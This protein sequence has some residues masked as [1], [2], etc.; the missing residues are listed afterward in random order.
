MI[1][2]SNL[3][4][5]TVFSTS[6]LGLPKMNAS[7][8]QAR[9]DA[10]IAA[11]IPADISI[12]NDILNRLHELFPQNDTSL[13]GRFNT[14]DS[15]FD[16][17]EAWFTDQMYLSPRRF[18]FEHVANLQPLF[19]YLFDEFFPG[20]DPNLG[21]FHGSELSLIFGGAPAS[22]SSIA[23]TFTDAYLNFVNDLNPGSF[24]SRYDL[25]DRKVLHWIS[26][27]ITMIPD[28]FNSTTIDFLN[29]AQ[30]INAFEK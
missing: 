12:S 3:N 17:A 1:M 23:T 28:D 9:F 25:Q 18:F 22:E 13:G 30:V 8:E 2:G 14:G 20:G 11:N 19:G 5:G 29:T 6:V 15:L 7:A 24:W 10:F 4:D 27:N 21:V 16:R 26:G